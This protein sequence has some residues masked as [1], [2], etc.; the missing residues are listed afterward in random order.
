MD[1]RNTT[2]SILAVMIAAALVVSV[3]SLMALHTLPADATKP[4][5]NR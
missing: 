4:K 5:H 1:Q 3:G 2:R